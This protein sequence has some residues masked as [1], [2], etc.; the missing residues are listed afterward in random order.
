MHVFHLSCLFQSSSYYGNGGGE[1]SSLFNMHNL[2]VVFHI[3]NQP[4]K[5]KLTEPVSESVHWYIMD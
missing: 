1:N 2:T 3:T 5:P 4:Q